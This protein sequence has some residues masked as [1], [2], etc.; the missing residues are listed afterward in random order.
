MLK[1]QFFHANALDKMTK[2]HEQLNSFLSKQ[3]D[4]AIVSV[5]ATELGYSG[6]Q[7]FYSYTVL[8]IYKAAG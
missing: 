8:V 1:A 3:Q 2:V 6:I 5:N 4:D 7:Q